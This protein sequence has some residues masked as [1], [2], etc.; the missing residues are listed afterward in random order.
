LS[1]DSG[2]PTGLSEVRWTRTT[3]G[4]PNDL[5]GSVTAGIG[6]KPF[7]ADIMRHLQKDFLKTYLENFLPFLSINSEEFILKDQIGSVQCI[8]GVN[9]LRLVL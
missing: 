9:Q 1:S 4:G 5:G 8:G 3:V 7:S 2:A 6:A